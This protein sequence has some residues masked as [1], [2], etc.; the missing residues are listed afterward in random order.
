M[1][2]RLDIKTL[3]IAILG[4]I[5]ICMAIFGKGGGDNADLEKL[6]EQRD[7]ENK[8]LKDD[9]EARRDSLA[10]WQDSITYYQAEDQLKAEIIL[11]LEEVR[12][13]QQ[14]DIN[15]L[16]SKLKNVD[17][18]IND[19]TDEQRMQFWRDYFQKRGIKP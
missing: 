11:A 14:L 10:M 15:F 7:E 5:I 19:A 2:T 17:K 6:L 16:K 1:I 3:V 4:I 8:Q 13:K 18:P 9:I 12:E